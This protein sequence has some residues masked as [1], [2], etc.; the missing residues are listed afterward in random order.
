MKSEN[1]FNFKEKLYFEAKKYGFELSENMLLNFEMYKN[2]LIEWNDKINLT[3]ITDEYQIIIKHFIDCLECIKYIEKNNNIIDVGTGAGF[4]GLVIGIYFD[5]K[6]N[7]TLLDSLNKRLIFLKE[8]IEKLNLKNI[9]IVHGRA[10]D[11]ANEAIF[12]EKYDVSLARAVASL[13]IL[14]EYTSPYV[15][16]GGKCIFMKGDNIQEEID[17]SVEAFKALNVKILKI[18]KY[19]LELLENT[20]IEVF[21]RSILEVKKIG[22]TPKN[23]PRSYAKIKISPL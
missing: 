16:V 23:Y 14:L 5:G 12:R 13:N 8:V 19:D 22:L 11:S 6:V 2:M 18:H 4:P 20:D 17:R 21:N 9:N 3:S 7:I 10:E 15:K 1:N